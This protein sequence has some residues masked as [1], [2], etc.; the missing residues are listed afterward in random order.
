MRVAQCKQS[1]CLPLKFLAHA[2]FHRESVGSK[3]VKPG[4]D[5]QHKRQDLVDGSPQRLEEEEQGNDSRYW[6]FYVVESKGC[7]KVSR[8]VAKGKEVK[9]RPEIQLRHDEIRHRVTQFPMTELMPKNCQ[10][11]FI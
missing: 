2:K 3:L 9:S 10:N 8:A 6:P 4:K 1:Q 7:R 5:C 11:L